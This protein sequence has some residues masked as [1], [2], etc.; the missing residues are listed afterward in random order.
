MHRTKCLFSIVFLL[1]VASCNAQ[2]DPGPRAG[3]PGAGPAIPTLKPNE[4]QFWQAALK[5]FQVV[6]SVTGTLEPGVGLGPTFNGNSC[7]MCHG[8]PSIG[9][10]S[11]GFNSPQHS[12]LNPQVALANLHGAANTLPAFI[13]ADGPV[14]VARFIQSETTPNT[15]DGGVHDL[16]TIHGRSDA[17]GCVLA[18]PDF[19]AQMAKNNVIFRIPTPI[20]GAGLVEDTPDAKLQANLA[21]NAT[22]KTSLGIAGRFNTS[23]NDG[24]ISRYG[25]KAQNKSLLMFAGEAENVEQGVTNELFPNERNATTS[26]SFTNTPEDITDDSGVAAPA[27]VT[28]SNI[29]EFAVF[30]RLLDQPHPTTASPAELAGQTLFTS[31]GCA[32]CHSPSLTAGKSPFT[33]MSNMTYH[34][35]SDFALHHMGSTLADGITQG[36]AGP[37]EFRTAPLWGL[38]QRLY[39]LHDGRTSNLLQAIADHASPTSG[40]IATTATQTFQVNGINFDPASPVNSCGSEADKVIANFNALTTTQ[41]QDLIDFLRS[42]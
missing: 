42:L 35:F 23:P 17:P 34:P 31:I 19:A 12:V 1:S 11:P 28:S 4:L 25:W 5:R 27:G 33:G 36:V 14:R 6:D 38:G 21:L 2:T 9:G 37:D 40:C 16:F 26:C 24:T 20:Y 29:V 30:M 10:S 32:V 13:T 3:A 8:Q 22:L 41:K 15:L 39:F 18:Q 7:A